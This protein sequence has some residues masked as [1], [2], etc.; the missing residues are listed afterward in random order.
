M[1]ALARKNHKPGSA[2]PATASTA[3]TPFVTVLPPSNTEAK[4]PWRQQCANAKSEATSLRWRISAR[5][6]TRALPTARCWKALSRPAHLISWA[7][8]VPNFLVVSMTPLMRPPQRSVTGSLGKFH[9]LMKQPLPLDQEKGQRLPG[10]SIKNFPTKRNYSVFT[11]A[12]IH[13]TRMRMFSRQKDIDRSL[14]W[15]IW[16][17]ARRSGLLVRLWTLRKS[18]QEKRESHSLWFGSKTGTRS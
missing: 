15:P 4:R 17:I 5:G 9:S 18:L 3:T 11:S 8:T 16:T 13:S 6:W 10:A 1:P 12:A 2:R 7:E 14:H